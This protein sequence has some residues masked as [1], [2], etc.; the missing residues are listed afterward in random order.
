MKDAKSVFVSRFASFKLPPGG[1][2]GASTAQQWVT[3]AKLM[4]ESGVNLPVNYDPK[5]AY[6]DKFIA[7]I[8]KFDRGAVEAQ[9][10]GWKD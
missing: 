7:E 1:M 6:T 3:T 5:S 10:R 2:Y 8:N 4:K 9:A